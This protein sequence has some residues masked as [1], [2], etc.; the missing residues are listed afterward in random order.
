MYF[1]YFKIVLRQL[2]SVYSLINLTGLIIGFA[3]FLL[4]YLW[5][6]EELSYDRFHQNPDHIFRVVYGR[7]WN[8]HLLKYR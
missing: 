6:M 4:I 8:T 1:N 5:V 2:R 3:A 7:G